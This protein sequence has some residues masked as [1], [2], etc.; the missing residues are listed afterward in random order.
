MGVSIWQLFVIAILFS[1]V[2]LPGLLALM[3]TKV[4]GKRKIFWFLAS[5]TAS[6][7]GYLIYWLV[8]VRKIPPAPNFIPREE[9]KNR[10]FPY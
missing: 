8:V 3:S 4:Y 9:N 5:F 10:Q 1:I 7:F 6:W 2:V